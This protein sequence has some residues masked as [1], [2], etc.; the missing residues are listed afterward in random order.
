MNIEKEELTVTE[1]INHLKGMNTEIGCD[2]IKIAAHKI[3]SHVRFVDK[4]G[5]S[6]RLISFDADRLGGCGCWD[7]IRIVL[8]K[9]LEED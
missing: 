8:E 4:E 7:G 2:G 1:F 6:Y 9:I 5:T 3:P